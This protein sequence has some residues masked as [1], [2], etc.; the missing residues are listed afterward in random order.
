MAIVAVAIIGLLSLA[1]YSLSR[2]QTKPWSSTLETLKIQSTFRKDLPQFEHK[3]GEKLINPRHFEGHWTLLTFWSYSCPPC[4]QE[5]P[6]LNALALSWQGGELEVLTVNTDPKDSDNFVFAKK[7]LQEEEIELPTVFD[8]DQ[9]IAKAFDV[10]VFPRHFLI[11]PEAKIVW[12]ASGAFAWN[13]P[14][15]RDQLLKLIE[16]RDPEAVPD[17]VE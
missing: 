16:P 10:T 15:A 11:N 7:F 8:R 6:A 5:M 17:P 2:M 4:L 9:V 12:E 3:D 14:K 1:I 13:D